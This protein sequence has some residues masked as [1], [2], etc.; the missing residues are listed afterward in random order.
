MNLFSKISPLEKLFNKS[1][2]KF[3]RYSLE[4]FCAK[5]SGCFICFAHEK[6]NY[7]PKQLLGARSFLPHHQMDHATNLWIFLFESSTNDNKHDVYLGHFAL[8]INS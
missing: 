5:I 6:L 1:W 3:F 7:V 2:L 4:I 8:E